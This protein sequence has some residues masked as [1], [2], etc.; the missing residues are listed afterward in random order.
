MIFGFQVSWFGSIYRW[1]SPAE[2]ENSP[3]IGA[4]TKL[5]FSDG[6]AVG[7]GLRKSTFCEMKL[8]PL[9]V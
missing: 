2:N 7:D 6:V 8:P 4:G 1:M 9:R 5:C 3:R